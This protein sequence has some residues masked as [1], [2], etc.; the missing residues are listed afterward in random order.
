MNTEFYLNR[1]EDWKSPYRTLKTI[2]RK[3]DRYVEVIP[4]YR[5]CEIIFELIYW[6][7]N[8]GHA[9]QPVSFCKSERGIKSKV[10]KY[11]NV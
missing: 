7:D 2:Y 8:I 3:D 6:K 5:G 10:M 4:F 9:V 11:L 1:K